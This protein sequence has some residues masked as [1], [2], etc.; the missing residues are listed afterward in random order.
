MT[1]F[2]KIINLLIGIV[3]KT[4]IG[5]VV[6]CLALVGCVSDSSQCPEDNPVYVA[7]SDVWVSFR[8]TNAMASKQSRYEDGEGHPEEAATAEENYI[9]PSDFTAILTDGENRFIKT[10]DDLA[11]TAVPNTDNTQYVIAGKINSGY[12]DLIGNDANFGILCVANT[13]GTGGGERL[14]MNMW[15]IT[16]TE[17]S[18]MRKAYAYAPADTEAWVPDS[19]SRHIPMSGFKKFSVASVRN[20]EAY[21]TPDNALQLGGISIQRAMAKIQ[22]IDQIDNSDRPYD[23]HISSATLY[24]GYGQGAV[25]PDLSRNPQWLE[26]TSAVETAASSSPYYL[27]RTEGGKLTFDEQ[28]GFVCDGGK[29]NSF[30]A[31]L[32]E[33]PAQGPEK[34]PFLRLETVKTENAVKYYTE[35]DILLSDVLPLVD[36]VPNIA[37]NHIYRFFVTMANGNIEVMASVHDWENKEYYIGDWDNVSV[38]TDK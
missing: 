17:I 8:I 27:W 20:A 23:V 7:G 15:M 9:N 31:Y 2:V 21:D 34:A 16:L 3:F 32:P 22:I 30:V 25:L 12:F 38:P 37:R 5:I 33:Q 28:P 29:Y 19:I 4:V 10:I 1:L 26:G 13:Q 14:G 6:P 24:N 18:A 35:Y 36:N 11:V